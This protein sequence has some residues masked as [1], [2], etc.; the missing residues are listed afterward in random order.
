MNSH[1]VN[2]ILPVFVSVI[3]SG[4]DNKEIFRDDFNGESINSTKWTVSEESNTYAYLLNGSLV[5]L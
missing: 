5:V 4:A 3:L 2:F 1:L